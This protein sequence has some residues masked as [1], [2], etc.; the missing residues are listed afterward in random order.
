MRSSIFLLFLMACVPWS[1]SDLDGDGLTAKQGDCDDSDAQVHPGA[2]DILGNQV[3]DNC[4]GVD[5]TDGDRDGHASTQTGGKDCDD[6]LDTVF[7]AADEI[8]DELDNDC[9]GAV[10]DDAVD[11]REWFE[12][13]DG[14]SF[15]SESVT[16][17]LACSEPF[18]ELIARGGD[19]D[20]RAAS[21]HPDAVD[22]C[23]RDFD[24]DGV[25]EPCEHPQSVVDSA[26]ADWTFIGGA[27]GDWAG[28]LATAIGD[29]NGDGYTDLAVSAPKHAGGGQIYIIEGPMGGG[30]G[31][32]FELS[33]ANAI[34]TGE[35]FGAQAGVSVAGLGDIDDDGFDDVLIGANLEGISGAAYLVYGPIPPTMSLADAD[36]EIIGEF[37]GDE[38]GWNV[39][40]AGDVDADG[41]PDL[42][43]AAPYSGF[44]SQGAVYLV[45][46]ADVQTMSL[47]DATVRFIGDI[48]GAS[49]G[50]DIAGNAD[51]NGDGLADMMFGGPLAGAG[52]VYIEHGTGSGTAQTEKNLADADVILLGDSNGDQAGSSVAFVG[53]IDGD[54]RADAAI[55]AP[56]A[57]LQG[58]E[59]GLVYLVLADPAGPL[60]GGGGDLTGA[61]AILAGSVPGDRAGNTLSAAGDVNGDGFD[62]FVVGCVLC[63]AGGE[64]F[65][66]EGP[67]LGEVTF[68]EVA[69]MRFSGLSSGDLVGASLGSADF[70]ADGY[71]DLIIGAPEGDGVPQGEGRAYLVFGGEP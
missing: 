24:C 8:C 66:V 54:G 46:A 11:A 47:A 67:V 7:P 35:S 59:V 39:A 44:A 12:D 45:S 34:L 53:D 22:Q 23:G 36:A 55:G 38:V 16:P 51:F 4:D 2:I 15:G 25:T 43:I 63:G 1:D 71:G 56:G 69:T 30:A 14:D 40:A 64:V 18:P 61:P 42:L 31:R 33:D 21:I 57:R 60:P 37:D 19:C 26:S 5:G 3:D 20:D 62:D 13:L 41:R 17:V 52:R 50:W 6:E 58:D 32:Q 28:Q 49:V 10:D 27:A 68:L 70:N 29:V 9:N 48:Q 65:L